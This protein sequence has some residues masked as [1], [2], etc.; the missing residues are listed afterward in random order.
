M[1]TAVEE[2]PIYVFVKN[3]GRNLKPA[4]IVIGTTI[5]IALTGAAI[6]P[7]NAT[8]VE[9]IVIFAVVAEIVALV[10]VNANVLVQVII[11]RKVL[12]GIHAIWKIYENNNE[13]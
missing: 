10:V 4:A 2:R 12:D 8:S 1:N 11:H 3:A 9:K 5:F 7:M 13:D 6:L